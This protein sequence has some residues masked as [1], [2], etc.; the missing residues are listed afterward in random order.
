MS[1]SSS[2]FHVGGTPIL[3]SILSGLIYIPTSIIWMP[4]AKVYVSR[5]SVF[6]DTVALKNACNKL[7]QKII[8][9]DI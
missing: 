8:Y 1:G 6:L 5:P 7:K 4:V 3:I 9:F 2:A